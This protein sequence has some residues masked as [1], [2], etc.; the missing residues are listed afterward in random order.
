MIIEGLLTTTTVDGTPH[1]APMGPLVDVELKNWTL[2][3]FSSS[4]TFRHLQSNPHCV[5]HVIDDV[6]PLV[7]AALGLPTSLSFELLQRDVNGEFETFATAE[8]EKSPPS[9][10]SDA[11]SLQSCYAGNVWTIP[12]ACH[13]YHLIVTDWDTSEPR[14]LAKAL[15]LSRHV[16]RPF[17]GWNRAKHAVMEAAILATRYHLVPH[18]EIEGDLQRLEQ[19]VHK[20]AGERELHAWHLLKDFF[21]ANS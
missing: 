9:L 18:T 6:V 3:P 14:T 12:S 1:M 8:R 15:L 20:T 5:F 2:R 4:N 7:E 13:W 19:V 17:W 11:S 16:Q 10:D 21:Q